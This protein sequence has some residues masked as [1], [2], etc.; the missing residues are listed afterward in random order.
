MCLPVALL[1]TPRAVATLWTRQGLIEV[2][3]PEMAREITPEKKSATIHASPHMHTDRAMARG[4]T[5]GDNE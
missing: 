3:H 5:E 2:Y 1:I 4:E